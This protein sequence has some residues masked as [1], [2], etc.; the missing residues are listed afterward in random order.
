V[1]ST[2]SECCEAPLQKHARVGGAVN[3]QSW[4]HAGDC[5][6]LEREC[7]QAIT[8]ISRD[9]GLARAD[10]T[11]GLCATRCAL[12]R[13]ALRRAPLV[14]ELPRCELPAVA[15]RRRRSTWCDCPACVCQNQALLLRPPQ[16]EMPRLPADGRGGGVYMC[17]RSSQHLAGMLIKPHTDQAAGHKPGSPCKGGG[18]HSVAGR[19]EAGCGKARQRIETQRPAL[20]QPAMKPPP[21]LQGSLRPGLAARRA[22]PCSRPRG[23][24]RAAPCPA[25]PPGPQ[26]SACSLEHRLRRPLERVDVVR[27]PLRRLARLCRDDEERTA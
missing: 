27:R 8:G 19:S 21:Q 25:P 15:C 10:T 6:L 5:L 11:S 9:A 16:K 26:R 14:R 3:L 12:P 24:Q 17:M 4:A 13:S 7:A 23:A 18:L 22:A 2:H 20:P 1:G